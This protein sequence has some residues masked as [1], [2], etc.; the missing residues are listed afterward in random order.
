M[1]FFSLPFE[2]GNSGFQAGRDGGGKGFRVEF[3]VDIIAKVKRW[4]TVEE[5]ERRL[6]IMRGNYQQSK[7]EK[8]E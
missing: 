6:I 3:I 1:I 2:I 8:V 4:R 7:R 5:T